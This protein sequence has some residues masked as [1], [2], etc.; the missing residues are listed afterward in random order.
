MRFF[1]FVSLLTT[2]LADTNPCPYLVTNDHVDGVWS[3]ASGTRPC[4]AN[5]VAGWDDL[6]PA[7]EEECTQ[8]C[9]TG[10]CREC[11]CQD[12]LVPDTTNTADRLECIE[13]EVEAVQEAEPEPEAEAVQE[14][15]N[16]LVI[17]MASY[18]A[19]VL[20]LAGFFVKS[21]LDN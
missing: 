2:T 5:A 19:F 14:E 11:V 17:T 4:S 20:V 1:V 15:N 12:G 13:P 9:W 16:T 8:H 7:T 18:G 3:C 6:C 10:S 21:I